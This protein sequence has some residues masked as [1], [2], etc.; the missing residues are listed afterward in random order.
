MKT[1]L[2]FLLLFGWFSPAL[3]SA[4][5]GRQDNKVLSK[6][7]SQEKIH[8]WCNRQPWLVGCDFIPSSAI[9]QLEMWQAEIFDPD[10]IDRELGWASDIG[11]NIIRVYLH[12][13]LWRQDS[14]GLKKRIDR[15][16]AITDK[17]HI[18]VMFVFFDSCWNP[19]PRL[20]RQPEPK[21]HVHNSGWVQSPHIELLKDTAKHDQLKDYVKGIINHFRN[22]NRVFVWDMYNEPGS[23]NGNRY[24]SYEPVNKTYLSLALLR[25]AFGWAREV[26]PRQ[27]I[28]AGLY[29]GQ[30]QKGGKLSPLNQFIL[31]NSD[32]ITF[33]S[34]D[35]SHQT[36]RKISALEQYNRPIICT[37]YMARTHGCTFE[38]ILPIFKERHVGAINWG[39]VA[40][41]TQTQYPWNSW[42][43]KYTAEPKLWFHDI[44]RP[45]GT[46][47]STKEV[48]FIKKLTKN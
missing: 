38:D 28:T 47:Y 37:E 48:E 17:H 10:T 14:A 43:K 13:L 11:F 5:E 25:K 16:L 40:G 26:D 19:H 24:G 27:P 23:R 9:N 1:V 18:K 32:V 21:P 2:S 7:W 42:T 33:H 39:L 36:T 44:F 31:D 30:W 3:C 41:K 45:D 12:D 34:Y 6:R 22:D 15:F 46:P 4:S 29:N 20:G 35:N 8:N